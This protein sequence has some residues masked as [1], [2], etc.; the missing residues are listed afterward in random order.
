MKD[1][2]DGDAPEFVARFKNRAIA[3]MKDY[4]NLNKQINLPETG[5][6]EFMNK[7]DREE[8]QVVIDKRNRHR[9][10][11]PKDDAKQLMD[12]LVKPGADLKT[13]MNEFALKK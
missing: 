6:E 2:W 4:Q 7:K 8:F 13:M 3:S 9:Q 11:F 5:I 1:C 12:D 10:F